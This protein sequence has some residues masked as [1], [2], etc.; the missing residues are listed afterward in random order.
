MGNKLSLLA[1]PS[2]SGSAA[3]KNTLAA[4]WIPRDMI[5]LWSSGVVGDLGGDIRC[6]CWAAAGS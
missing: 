4:G 2:S 1:S 6:H 3:L 5:G